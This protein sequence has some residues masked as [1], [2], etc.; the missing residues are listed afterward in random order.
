M[1]TAI[2]YLN[3][4]LE[5][6]KKELT[7]LSQDK[8]DEAKTLSE[9]RNWLISQAWSVR[10]GCDKA[11]YKDKLLQIQ[12]MQSQLTAEATAQKQ[13]VAQGLMRS[14]KENKRMLGYKQAMVG[15]GV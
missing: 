10:Q 14:K 1:R 6:G 2:D 11:T 8:L 9:R 15:Y 7:A 3:E 13:K 12:S 5:L 4:A